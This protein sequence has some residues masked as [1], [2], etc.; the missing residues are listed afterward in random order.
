MLLLVGHLELQE[1][2]NVSSALFDGHDWFPYTMSTKYDGAPGQLQQIFHETRCC[3]ITDIIRKFSFVAC[4]L[5]L[6][7][8]VSHSPHIDTIEIQ[9]SDI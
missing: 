8:S 1:Y 4:F 3:T 9:H 6:P 2:G 7:F 5:F